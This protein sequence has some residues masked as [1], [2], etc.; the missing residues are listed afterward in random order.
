V[1]APKTIGQP[2]GRRGATALEF[3]IL[4]FPFFLLLLFLFELGLDFYVQLAL[5]Y[6]VQEGARKLQTGAGNAAA[7]SDIFKNDCLCP[8]VA[9]FLNCSQ[10]TLNVYPVPNSSP[11]GGTGDFYTNALTGAGSLPINNGTVST[12]AWNL[13]TGT[14]NQLMFMQAI[15][16]SV[17]VVGI[18]LP[19]MSAISGSGRVHVT[20]SSIGFINEPFTAGSK[21]CGV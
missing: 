18:L 13:T 2:L 10:L 16:T 14:A 19:Q 11:T 6:A 12:G 21:V 20:T 8:P 9:A 7:S 4:A 5:D 1:P 17:S 3:A 15:Y